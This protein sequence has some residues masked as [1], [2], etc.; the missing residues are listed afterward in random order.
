MERN[1]LMMKK[2]RKEQGGVGRVRRVDHLA[3]DLDRQGRNL[4][5][6]VG[7]NRRKSK[8]GLN[9][10]PTSSWLLKLP[11]VLLELD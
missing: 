3:L 10:R 8:S 5:R 4:K 11:M 7:R 6:I 1:S 9:I 2:K